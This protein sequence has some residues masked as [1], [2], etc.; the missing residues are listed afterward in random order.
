MWHVIK[1]VTQAAAHVDSYEF[2]PRQTRPKTRTRP[3][4]PAPRVGAGLS[5]Q[6]RGRVC[7]LKTQP[8]THTGTQITH[9]SKRGRICQLAQNYAKLFV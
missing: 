3:R 6:T 2:R 5:Q 9:D 8:A 4:K 7:F 1:H